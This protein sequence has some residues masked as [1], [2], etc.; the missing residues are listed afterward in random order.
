MKTLDK[1]G[2]D[3]E[4]TIE[5]NNGLGKHHYSMLPHHAL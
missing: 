1:E 4:G 5:F 2:L 3:E